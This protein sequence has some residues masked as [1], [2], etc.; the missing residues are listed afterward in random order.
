MIVVEVVVVVVVEMSPR[1]DCFRI[2]R[3]T[4]SEWRLMPIPTKK[5]PIPTHVC[6]VSTDGDDSVVVLVVVG[7]TKG[8]GESFRICAK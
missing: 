8:N 2:F 5:R 7:S 1:G 3:N 4:P 6:M